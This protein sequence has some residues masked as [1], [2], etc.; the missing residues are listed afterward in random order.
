MFNIATQFPLICDRLSLPKQGGLNKF[1][2]PQLFQN[3]FVVFVKKK[4]VRF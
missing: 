3:S 4:S 2:I 1:F